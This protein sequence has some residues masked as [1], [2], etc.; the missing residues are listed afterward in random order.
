MRAGY[1]GGVKLQFIR[2]QE[3]TDGIWSFFF[4][5]AEPLTWLAGQS[6]RLEIPRSSW[7][8]DER[9]FTIASAPH[10]QHL[11]ITTRRSDSSFKQNLF[12]LQA[13]T[14]I[15]A[16]GVEGSFI[17]GGEKAHRL[18]I[19]AGIGI[20]P[21]RAMLSQRIADG[22]ALDATLV[23]AS[24]DKPAA[25][26]DELQDW[27]SA[28]SDLRLLQTDQRLFIGPDSSLSEH[29]QKSI[30]YVSGPEAM[31]KDLT[32]RLQAMGVADKRI[33]RDEFTGNL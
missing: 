20:T 15:N 32:A 8:V 21:Y 12:A 10:E 1:T 27:A 26:Q 22:Q 7:G 16:F 33:R 23:Y 13:G 11:R 28:Y 25:F 24:S 17:W 18:F 30:I 29:W 14:P 31:V 9:R 3:E 5:P 6:I 4:E 19:A 2:K